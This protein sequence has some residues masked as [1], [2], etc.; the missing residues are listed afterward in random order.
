MGRLGEK[1]SNWDVDEAIASGAQPGGPHTHPISDV[2]DLQ[3]TLDGKA[4]VSHSHIIADVSGL[5]T[6]L[7]GKS[8]SDH[9][10][11]GSSGPT[12]VKLTV[13]LAASTVVTLANATGLSFAI[14]SGT[15]YHFK[16]YITF[17]SAA[18]TT[19]IRLGL[20]FPAITRFASTANIPIA[21]DG[22]GGLWQGWITTSGDAVV[23]TGVQ[24]INTDYL[25]I[26][27]GNILPSADGT[28]QLQ[29]ATEVAGS[30]V[31]VRQGS[32]GVLY[33]L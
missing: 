5:Q 31:T 22:A 29:F 13:D 18:T 19:G 15:Y 10:H 8:A 24:A 6:A 7:D 9:T 17:R 27:E 1:G 26:V 33:S 20:T 32:C 4:V 2:T 16:F 14:V 23:G 3:T 30:A 11:P 21:A 12:T 25:A 28:L